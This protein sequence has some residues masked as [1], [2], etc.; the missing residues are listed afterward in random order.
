MI[1]IEYEND[2]D[3]V[4]AAALH[5][6]RASRAGRRLQRRHL[7]YSVLIVAAGGVALAGALMSVDV[8][9]GTVALACGVAVVHRPLFERAVRRDVR[10]NYTRDAGTAALGRHRLDLAENELM[11]TCPTGIQSTRYAAIHGIAETDAHVFIYLNPAQLYMIPRARLAEDELER[12]V[13]GLR[14]RLGGNGAV[15]GAE[16][17]E[18]DQR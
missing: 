9:A 17:P 4:V 11:E 12:F 14:Q 2:I 1:T 8:L 18:I 15:D 3:D 5:Q 6:C 13:H 7:E 16:A 10:R